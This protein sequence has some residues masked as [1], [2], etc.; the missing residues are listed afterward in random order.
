MPTSARTAAGVGRGCGSRGPGAR[1]PLLHQPAEHRVGRV[2]RDAL[3][4]RERQVPEVEVARAP[5]EHRGVERDHERVAAGG[6]GPPDQALDELVRRRPVQL[7]PA[8]GVAH[9]GGA[10]LHRHRRLVGEDHRHAHRRRR[11]GHGEVG[12]VVH[13]LEGARPGRAAAGRAAGGRTARPRSPGCSR[14]AAPAAPRP[15]GRR[16]PGWP[17]ASPRRRRRPRRRSR[18][19][20]SAPAWPAPA[21]VR[22][23]V[24][25]SGWC[26]NTPAR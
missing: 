11:A 5:A 7:E 17:A 15:T 25:T 8:R 13:Q 12:L 1:R 23:A 2:L 10:L 4:Q 14:R 3:A 26:P 21:A 19:G 18:R 6:L 24:G 22:A 9:R 20:R 16:R